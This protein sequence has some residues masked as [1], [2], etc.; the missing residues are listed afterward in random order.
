MQERANANEPL[1]CKFFLFKFFFLLL[2]PVY[3]FFSLIFW[4]IFVYFKKW[5]RKILL[6]VIL[7]VDSCNNWIWY[8]VLSLNVELMDCQSSSGWFKKLGLMVLSY[9]WHWPRK[10][11]LAQGCLWTTMIST[12][13]QHA[14]GDFSCFFDSE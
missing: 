14:Q 8:Y 11:M 7:F 3:S 13:S 9:T 1:S 6:S 4:K 5:S 2:L 10:P 12:N